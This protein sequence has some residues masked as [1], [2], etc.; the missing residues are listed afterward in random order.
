[1]VTFVFMEEGN[2][3]SALCLIVL[4]CQKCFYVATRITVLLV[5][6]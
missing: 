2:F 5:M 1:M 3:I 4:H 6:L